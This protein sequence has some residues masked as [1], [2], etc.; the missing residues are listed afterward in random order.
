[1]P[2]KVPYFKNI[3]DSVRKSLQRACVLKTAVCRKIYETEFIVMEVTVCKLQFFEWNA[4]P[5]MFNRD[6]PKIQHK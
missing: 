1:M 3:A 2:L 5:K 4:P 6:L